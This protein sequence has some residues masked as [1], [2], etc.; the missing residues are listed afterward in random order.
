MEINPHIHLTTGQF[1]KLMGV[2]KDTLFHYDR[3]GIFSPEIK[4]ENGYRYY[5][6]NQID[7]F[8]VIVTLKELK[9]PLKE[10]KQYISKR[11]PDEL[12][13]LLEK[14]SDVLDAKIKKLQKMK[15]NIK[16]KIISTKAAMKINTFDIISEE[17]EEERFVLTE[18]VPFTGIKSIY[19][20]IL[21]HY[22]YLNTYNID[23]PHSAGWM[24]DTKKVKA[25]DTSNYDYLFT[26]VSKAASHYH[27][28][29]EK[30][31]YIT[32][33]YTDGD[34]SIDDTYDRLLRFSTEKGLHLHDFFYEEVLLD[35][36]SIRGYESYLIQVS[37][38]VSK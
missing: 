27:F 19:D 23:T 6:I 33:Y 37:V 22:N 30:G 17:K 38:Q 32:A 28:K 1:A 31:T 18:A 29:R 14:E 24:I 9:M 2:G 21:K 16:E 36:L 15:N 4:A 25:K 35:E 20:S 34:S 7:I 5:S 12:I 10:I 13:V 8:N 26:R 3:I 11:S